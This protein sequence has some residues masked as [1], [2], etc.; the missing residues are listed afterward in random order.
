MTLRTVTLSTLCLVSLLL[1]GCGRAPVSTSRTNNPEVPVDLL[2]EHDG[3]KVYR[4]YD[5]GH[6][7][8]YTDARGATAWEQSQGKT[9]FPVRVET[10]R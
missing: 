1:A 6:T 3:V 7:V 5:N 8:Y 2:F 9:S 4:F 10:A